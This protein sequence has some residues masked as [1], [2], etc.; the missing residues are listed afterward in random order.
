MTA[1]LIVITFD[2]VP[3]LLPGLLP[4]LKTAVELTDQLRF[5]GRKETLHGSIV[6]WQLPLRLM[7]HTMS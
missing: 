6:P 3:H 2:V 5:Q 4:I 1:I 7:L